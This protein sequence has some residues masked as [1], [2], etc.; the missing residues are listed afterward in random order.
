[1]CETR[2]KVTGIIQPLEGKNSLDALNQLASVAR[3]RLHAS[4]KQIVEE[5]GGKY[6]RPDPKDAATCKAK[7]EREYKGDY[8]RLLDL[9]RAT[10]LFEK[11][12]GMLECLRRM[13]WNKN[14]TC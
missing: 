9:E 7:V 1:V 5:C 12:Q 8:S 4:M 13:R 14:L 3:D 11:P 2:D 6:V 10:G